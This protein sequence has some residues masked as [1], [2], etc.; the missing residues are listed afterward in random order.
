[1]KI[2]ILNGPNLNM[3]GKREP[4]HY[5]SLTLVD[6]EVNIH[7]KAMDLNIE[8]SFFQSNIEGELIEKIQQ[9]EQD[10]FDGV[11][12]NPGAY[13]HYSIAIR[14]AIS[15]V[16]T[17]FIEVHLSNVHAREEFRHKSV[18]AGV[19][20]GQICGFGLQSYIMGLS[21]LYRIIKNKSKQ[22]E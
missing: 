15:S 5:G 11:V 7:K 9:V 12:F 22:G 19:C 17:P 3:L 1:M 13:T 4:E 6:L 10:K 18:T 20:L 2:L 21:E 16:K 8:T 14:D